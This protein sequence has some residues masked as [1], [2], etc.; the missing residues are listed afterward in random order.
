MSKFKVYT[1]TG[2]GGYTSLIGPTRVK[3]DDLR[4]NAYGAVDELNSFIGLL[5]ANLSH[6]LALMQEDLE[7]IQNF[8]FKIG[9]D[10]ATD[11]SKKEG[12]LLFEIVSAEIDFLEN[13]MDEMDAVLPEL[14]QFILP[15]GSKEAANAHCCRSI[16]RRVERNLYAM[17]EQ[18]SVNEGVLVYIN[19][20]SDFFFVLSRYFNV[21]LNVEE[22]KCLQ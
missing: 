7:R 9:S 17:N 18:F 5:S 15:S 16:S 19:R 10:L 8:L 2:D 6:E 4:V 1:K 11:K 21:I 3:K 12:N 22:K 14:Q 13:R 20:L